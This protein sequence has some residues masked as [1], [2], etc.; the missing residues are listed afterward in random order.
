MSIW[1][2]TVAWL[3]SPRTL[4]L[5]LNLS[6]TSLIS[7][8]GSVRFC[9]N[10]HLN[11]YTDLCITHVTH[12]MY[13]CCN[14]ILK[15]VSFDTNYLDSGLLWDSFIR[16]SKNCFFFL[17]LFYVSFLWMLECPCRYTSLSPSDRIW[18]CSSINVPQN[19]MNTYAL[20]ML[21]N[22]VAYSSDITPSATDR[23]LPN[24]L[25][26][27]GICALNSSTPPYSFGTRLKCLREIAIRQGSG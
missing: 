19:V 10:E 18:C 1:C 27:K 20:M 22:L 5:K 24:Q 13:K 9:R 23:S 14:V 15:A 6:L 21:N 16:W 26:D 11:E 8:N 4:T 17:Q 2:C 3:R 7:L 12:Q 25:L